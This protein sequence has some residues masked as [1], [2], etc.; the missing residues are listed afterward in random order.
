MKLFPF[1]AMAKAGECRR[2]TLP[3]RLEL[4]AMRQLFKLSPFTSLTAGCAG[5]VDTGPAA[6]LNLV[7]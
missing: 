1:G 3:G 7:Y 5:A 4:Y 2:C 6:T